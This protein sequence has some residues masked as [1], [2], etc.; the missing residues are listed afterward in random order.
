MTDINRLRDVIQRTPVIDNHAHNLLLPTETDSHPFHL[1][2]TEAHGE[3]LE[4]AFTSLSHIRACKQLKELYE[5]EGPDEEWT[6][7]RVL[8]IR[9][10]WVTSR[11]DE[12]NR[13]CLEGTHVILMDDGLSLCD[14]VYPFQ[15]HDSFTKAPTRR[16]IRIE[17]EAEL[18][19]QDLL[20]SATTKD[21][22]FEEFYSNIYHNFAEL[23]DRTIRERSD[24]SQVAGFKSVICYRSGLDVNP[25][26]DAVVQQVREPFHHYIHHAVTN[27][28]DPRRLRFDYKPLNDYLLLK[29]LQL[30][31]EYDRP[32]PIQFHTGLGD[33]DMLLL[34]S[35]PAHLQRLIEAYPSVPFVLLHSAYPYTRE[36]GYLTTVFK[37]VYLDLGEVFP[38]IS[39][40]GQEDVIRQALELTPAGKLLWSTDGH[41][42][43]ERYW[44]ANK[45]FRE[46]LEKVRCWCCISYNLIPCLQNLSL[47]V[48]KIDTVENLICWRFTPSC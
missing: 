31:S 48:H 17:R 44:L 27:A 29:T 35:N 40:N 21:T 37:N 1:I 36:A 30:L 5:Y 41:L 33:N 46:V 42:F 26:Y 2:T 43:G 6:W 38:M 39:T 11:W 32:K 28:D 14:K 7:E 23:F 4:D 47:L 8:G 9:K 18:I 19:M 34:H 13:K 10:E 45:Q 16:I 3:A 22:Q 20:A 24:D 25:D 12:L 15:W